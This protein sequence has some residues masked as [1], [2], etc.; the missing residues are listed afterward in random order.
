MWDCDL[1]PVDPADLVVLAV[2]VVVAVLRAP[3]FV[4]GQ[5]HRH[6]AREHQDGDEVPDLPVAQGFD[7]GI[8]GRALDAAVPAQV[9]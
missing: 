3:D 5:D 7:G 2:G 6:A 1:R 4:A 9:S 8:V